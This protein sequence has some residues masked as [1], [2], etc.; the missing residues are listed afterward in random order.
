MIKNQFEALSIDNEER[1]RKD[2]IN[3]ERDIVKEMEGA[4]F[5]EDPQTPWKKV[6]PQRRKRVERNKK[7]PSTVL[8]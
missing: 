4:A 2:K 8:V 3:I 7:K 6:A 5:L 1:E